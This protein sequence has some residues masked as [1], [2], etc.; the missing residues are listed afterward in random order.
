MTA[1]KQ[2]INYWTDSSSNYKKHIQKELGNYKKEFWAD[3]ILSNAPQ[4]EKLRILDVGTGPGFFSIILT[5]LGHDVTGIDCT[6]AMIKVARENAKSEGVE[7]E[8]IQ[9]DADRLY[10]ESNTF[11]LVICRNVTWTLPNPFDC[12][13]EWKRVLM[14]G[15]RILIFDGNWYANQFNEEYARIMYDDIRSTLIEDENALTMHFDF[16]VRDSFWEKLPLIGAQRP[17]WDKRMLYKLRFTDVQ[18]RENIMS[19]TRLEED[20][21]DSDRISPLFMVRAEKASPVDEGRMILREYSDGISACLSADLWHKNKSGTVDEYAALLGKYIKEGSEVLDLGCGCG[22]A[23]QGLARAGRKVTG[24]DNSKH[25]LYELDRSSK[26]MGTKIVSIYSEMD[27]TTLKDESVDAVIC[28]K[29]LWYSY[30]PETVVS[31]IRR[32]LRKGGVAIIEDGN[33]LNNVNRSVESHTNRISLA[34]LR[35]SGYGIADAIS[36]ALGRL[37]S[38]SIEYENMME[39][40]KANGFDIVSSS[41]KFDDPLMSED[42]KATVGYPYLIVAS[43]F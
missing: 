14:P 35:D 25:M 5:K 2:T 32:V 23:S 39:M 43:K 36:E 15:G 29:S 13:R 16:H 40:M 28:R 17:E 31:E 26:E 8:F 38:T 18:T 9:M 24:V 12:Y 19:G 10:F 4:K 34:K 3:L 6:E 20:M 1:D 41:A 22:H 33:W 42:E 21:R 37:P 11:D 7:I 30:S 27:C